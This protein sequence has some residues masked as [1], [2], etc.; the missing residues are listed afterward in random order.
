MLSK[1]EPVLYDVSQASILGV[2][3][4]LL[5]FDDVGHVLSNCNII[6]TAMGF[7]LTTT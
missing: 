6:M 7:E 3:L 4:F 5:G 2:L 1:P